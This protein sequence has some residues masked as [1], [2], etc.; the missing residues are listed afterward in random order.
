MKTAVSVPDDLFDQV[1]RFARG[2]GRSRSEVYSTALREY[3]ECHSPDEVTEALD[4]VI[5][6][7]GRQA[8]SDEFTRSAAR[9]VLDASEW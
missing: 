6:K 8:A 7:V 9:R 3:M 4:R 1:D 2:A 5:A